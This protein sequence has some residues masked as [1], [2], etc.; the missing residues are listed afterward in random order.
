MRRL[1]LSLILI[2]A[3]A[4]AVAAYPSIGNAWLR[5]VPGQTTGAGYMVIENKNDAPVTL[6]SVTSACCTAI[7]M[8]EMLMDGDNMQMRQ[9]QA[10]EVP[11]H[12]SVKFE[13]MGY[14]LMFIGLTKPPH[15]KDTV[16][17]MLHFSDGS[18]IPV[19]FTVKLVSHGDME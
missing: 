14:H 2:C 8:H 1:L 10:V 3:A 4:P 6:T 12:G 15:N 5:L 7:E 13:S 17:A 19:G 16:T 18:D 9:V 11:A